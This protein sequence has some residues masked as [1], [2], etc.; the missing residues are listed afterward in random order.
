VWNEVKW[1]LPPDPWGRG[2]AFVCRAADCGTE[3]TLYLRAKI[4][5]CNCTTGVADDEELERVADL[6]LFGS[7]REATAPGRLIAV[8]SMRGRARPY[9]LT[10]AH[11]S[12]KSALAIA[13]NERCDV[14]VA[15]VLLG[16]EQPATI[17]PAV[18]EL[19]NGDV[20]MRWAEVTLGL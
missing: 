6:D 14:I 11:P 9:T 3:V 5:F 8:A 2:L 20:V 4:G 18:L 19:L 12:I 13:F 7:G 16:R 15:T 10:G 1:P 17:E